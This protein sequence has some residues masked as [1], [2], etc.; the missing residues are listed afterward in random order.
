M[1]K[2][3]EEWLVQQSA[4]LGNFATLSRCYEHL[5]SDDPLRI[6]VEEKM[7]GI[8]NMVEVG[9]PN[10]TELSRQY[11][12]FIKGLIISNL[13]DAELHNVDHDIAGSELLIT[14][15]RAGSSRRSILR[16]S[17]SEA[18]VVTVPAT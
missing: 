18:G 4:L 11:T 7:R 1:G 15:S 14:V 16:I 13:P 8:L 3:T 12:S 9:S 10:V 5:P 2:K 6:D 17:V